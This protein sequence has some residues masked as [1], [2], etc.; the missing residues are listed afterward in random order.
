MNS[1]ALDNDLVVR[2]TKGII[3]FE[4]TSGGIISYSLNLFNGLSEGFISCIKKLES[5]Q[6]GEEA[7]FHFGKDEDLIFI[8][9][10]ESD[11]TVI[12]DTGCSR[13]VFVTGKDSLKQFAIW[14]KENEIL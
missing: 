3:F 2:L 14:L 13:A 8:S 5:K 12:I 6:D 1:F 7:N 11:Y 9:N 4:S 10:N